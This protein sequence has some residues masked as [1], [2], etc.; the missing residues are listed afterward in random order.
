MVKVVEGEG[1][2]GAYD[3][4]GFSIR[5]L[6]NSSNVTRRPFSS[7]IA[8]AISLVSC[9]CVSGDTGINFLINIEYNKYNRM[10]PGGVDN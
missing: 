1:D 3:D 5:R 9:A 8:C 7:S 6:S 10:Q 2:V 4:H